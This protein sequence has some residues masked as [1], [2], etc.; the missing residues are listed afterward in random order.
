M[1][2]RNAKDYAA[3]KFWVDRNYYNGKGKKIGGLKAVEREWLKVRVI[4]G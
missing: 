3:C 1:R 4:A 2:L